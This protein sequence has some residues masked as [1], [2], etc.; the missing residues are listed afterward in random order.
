MCYK[1]YENK[2]LRVKNVERGS[3]EYKANYK[4]MFIV[5][6]ICGCLFCA[7]LSSLN[8]NFGPFLG[9]LGAVGNSV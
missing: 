4:K 3:E 2:I 1:A 5:I 7:G 9:L 8:F 6:R